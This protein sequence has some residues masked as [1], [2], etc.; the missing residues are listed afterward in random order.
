MKYSVFTVMLP[1]LSPEEAI[2]ALKKAGYDG[3]EWRVTAID[4]AKAEEAPSF[5]GNNRCTVDIHSSEEQILS[6]KAATEQAGLEIPAL[7]CYLACGDVEGTERGMRIAQWL[8]AAAIRVGVPMY[9]RSKRYQEL[10]KEGRAYLSQ[11]QELSRRYGV[12]GWIEIHM[13]NIATSASLAHKLVDGFD[14]AHIG[15]IYDPGNMVYEGYEQYRMGLELLGPYLAHVHVKN[16]HWVRND[17]PSRHIWQADACPVPDGVANWKQILDDLQ[18]VG[19]D[20]WLSF[21]DFS[22]SAPSEELLVRNLQYMK[23]L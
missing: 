6:L 22:R 15:V 11:V 20:R 13:N 9:N 4:P 2:P 16:A 19:Y 23:S 7:A 8:G 21:E 1:E 14:P 17:D 12:Q 5:W 18:A 10:L 3:V